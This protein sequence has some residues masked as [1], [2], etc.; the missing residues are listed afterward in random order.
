M[1]ELVWNIYEMIL[2]RDKRINPPEIQLWYEAG[3][4][5]PET[6]HGRCVSRNISR[7]LQACLKTVGR[8]FGPAA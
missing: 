8:Y 5:L 2:G 1:H 7:K 4:Q 3:D 6:W